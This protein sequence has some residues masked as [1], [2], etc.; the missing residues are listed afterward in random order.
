[1]KTSL[2]VLCLGL[3]YSSPKG[4]C[5]LLQHCTAS[6][7]ITEG[8]EEQRTWVPI[9]PP[10]SCFVALGPLLRSFDGFLIYKTVVKYKSLWHLNGVFRTVSGFEYLV[11]DWS[12][13][14][15]GVALLEDACHC[16]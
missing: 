8:K 7:D 11:P 9:Q 12:C 15:E 16:G 13:C 1:M 2:L 6:G 14:L 5:I 4:L 10:L 3:W